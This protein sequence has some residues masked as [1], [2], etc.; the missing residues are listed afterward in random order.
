MSCLT[1]PPLSV[2]RIAAAFFGIALI[3]LTDTITCR[4]QT[5]TVPKERLLQSITVVFDLNSQLGARIDQAQGLRRELAHQLQEL[6]AESRQ[7]RDQLQITS[8][9]EAD[10]CPRIFYNLKLMGLLTAYVTRLDHKIG[11]LQSGRETLQTLMRQAEDDARIIDTL[12]DL[13]VDRLLNRMARV[14]EEY[15]PEIQNFLFRLDEGAIASSAQVWEIVS[16]D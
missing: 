14:V 7:Q 15:R 12:N 3:L 10:K 8:Y 2:T 1:L 4:A 9:E 5:Q 11:Y 16:A 13:K 6:I